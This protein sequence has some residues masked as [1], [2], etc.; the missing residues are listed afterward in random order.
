MMSSDLATLASKPQLRNTTDI[1]ET[2]TA[3]LSHQLD[4]FYQ[5]ILGIPRLLTIQ[6]SL[7]YLVGV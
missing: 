2:A 3:E 5:S 1:V 4:G 7:I 6:Q